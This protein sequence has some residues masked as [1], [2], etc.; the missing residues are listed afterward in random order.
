MLKKTT[1][2]WYESVER[3]AQRDDR[4][5][6]S[7][8]AHSSCVAFCSPA[9]QC[10]ILMKHSIGLDRRITMALKLTKFRY[11][12]RCRVLRLDSYCSPADSPAWPIVTV[13]LA[14]GSWQLAVGSANTKP[15]WPFG[16]FCWLVC[17]N[18]PTPYRCWLCEIARSCA[19]A[20]VR[21]CVCECGESAKALVSFTTSFSCSVYL[22]ILE[23]A[24]IC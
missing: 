14:A 8:C 10:G 2:A 19:Q 20:G 11:S 9:Q 13:Q 18:G 23:Y 7:M 1:L 24:Y 15:L 16:T 4:Q 22:H 12:S 21:V 5:G 3:C 17:V 6:R